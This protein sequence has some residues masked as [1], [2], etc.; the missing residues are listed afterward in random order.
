[1][2]CVLYMELVTSQGQNGHLR[3]QNLFYGVHGNVF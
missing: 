3:P 1:M 2:N